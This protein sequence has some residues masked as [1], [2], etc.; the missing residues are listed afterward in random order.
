MPGVPAVPLAGVPPWTDQN[1][2]LYHGT[3]DLWAADILNAIDLGQAQPY[4]DFGRGFYTTSKLDQARRWARDVARIWGSVPAVIEFD[5]ERNAIAQLECMFFIRSSAA[6]IDFWSFVQY[7][8]TIAGDH[9]R[10]YQPGYYDI[11]AGPVPGNWKDQTVIPDS[12]QISFHTDAAVRV[13]D[14]LPAIRKRQVP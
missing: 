2:L 9:N 10:L 12:D 14:Q 1:I 3:A 11:V 6:A 7:C 5:V 13:L 4:T 8:K